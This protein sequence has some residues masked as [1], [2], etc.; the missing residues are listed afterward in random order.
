MYKV[1][2][3][4]G[5]NS[6]PLPLVEALEYAFECNTVCKIINLE[7]NEELSEDCEND[8]C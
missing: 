7:T 4:T 3:P 1:I 5:F 8:N 2:V 6:I